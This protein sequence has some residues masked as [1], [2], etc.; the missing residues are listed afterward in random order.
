[1]S[2]NGAEWRAEVRRVR[3]EQARARRRQP[4]RRVRNT[5]PNRPGMIRAAPATP[6]NDSQLR[7]TRN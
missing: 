5:M 3:A 1:M 7:T 6:A 2:G 4:Y